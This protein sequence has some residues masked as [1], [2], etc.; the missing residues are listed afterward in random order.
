MDYGKEHSNRAD[1]ARYG[2][3][4]PRVYPTW[5]TLSNSNEIQKIQ[6][7]GSMQKG[8]WNLY[9]IDKICRPP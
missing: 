2:R 8:V 7:N 5:S 6:Y 3:T 9:W 4:Y 1:P